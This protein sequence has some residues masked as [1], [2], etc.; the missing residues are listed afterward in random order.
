MAMITGTLE[1]ITEQVNSANV[2]I[3]VLCAYDPDVDTFF[4]V[5]GDS[6]TGKINVD[7]GA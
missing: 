3:A 2:K 4:V 7:T 6:T 5:T 1:Q